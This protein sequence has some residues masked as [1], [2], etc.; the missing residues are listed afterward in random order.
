MSILV[1]GVNHHSGPLSVLERV[2]LPV[3]EIPKAVDSLVRRDNVREVAVLSTC[4]RT[5][6][7]AVAER[8]HGAYADIRDFLCDLGH[9]P[10]DELHPH[11]YSQHDELAVL[12]VRTE[13]GL[14]SHPPSGGPP[15]PDEAQLS[16]FD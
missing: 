6:I 3:D 2:T 11:L 15:P 4:N 13:H 8:F 14:A 12:D 9:I 10:P 1:I 7:Y 5:E 16:L